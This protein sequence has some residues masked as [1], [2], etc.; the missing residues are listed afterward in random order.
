[1]KKI[2]LNS[3]MAACSLLFACILTACRQGER[4]SKLDQYQVEKHQKD[5]VALVEQERTLAYFQSLLEAQMPVID[6]LIPLFKYEQKNAKYQD[7]GY[8]VA[9][10]RNGLRILVRD[11]GNDLLM[12]RNGTRLDV[13]QYRL[14]TTDSDY[15]L[16]ERAMHLQIVMSDI[17]ELEKR[18]R[19]T[20]LEIQKYQKRLQNP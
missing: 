10:G 16:F 18:I 6:S 13:D 15:P 5:S 19:H 2:I 11:D 9:T 20:S 8:Y 12:Y 7:H 14:K 3:T 17:Q 4:A 1:M